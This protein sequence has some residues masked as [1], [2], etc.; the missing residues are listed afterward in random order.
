MADVL[1]LTPERAAAGLAVLDRLDEQDD[2]EDD[3]PSVVHIVRIAISKIVEDDVRGTKPMTS[4]LSRAVVADLLDIEESYL[5]HAALADITDCDVLPMVDRLVHE[6][7]E[8]DIETTDLDR[9]EVVWRKKASE[10][11]GMV[12]LGTCKPVGKREREA[13]RGEGRAPWWR[14]T[15]ALDVWLLMTPEE[16]WRLVHHELMHR[17]RARAPVRQSPDGSSIEEGGLTQKPVRARALPLHSACACGFPPVSRGIRAVGS[18]EGTPFPLGVCMSTFSARLTVAMARATLSAPEVEHKID[19]AGGDIP[20]KRINRLRRGD[21]EPRLA[22]V[23][24][25]AGA[26]GVPPAYLA[27]WP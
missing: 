20:A 13:W 4:A 25:L 7:T 24:L 10:S 16:R 1:T 11:A 23:P 14:V 6:C 19:L 3:G 15:L 12:V 8:I 2:H 9:V 27:G 22:E 18:A 26:L 21:V 5:P 17:N